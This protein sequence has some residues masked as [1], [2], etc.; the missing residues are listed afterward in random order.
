MFSGFPDTFETY[1]AIRTIESVNQDPL[2]ADHRMEG[3]NV[4]LVK[5]V[6]F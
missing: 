6:T 3:Y 5:Q 1:Y 4:I 2:L